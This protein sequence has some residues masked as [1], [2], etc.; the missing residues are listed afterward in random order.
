MEAIKAQQ[1]ELE[2]ERGEL[3]SQLASAEEGESSLKT[4]LTKVI[5]DSVD[6]S[7]GGDGSY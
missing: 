4:Q 6:K 2:N 3:R 1:R 7:A 5:E